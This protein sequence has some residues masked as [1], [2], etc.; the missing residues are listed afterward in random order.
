[1]AP[2]LVIA[3]RGSSD[4]FPE[5]T[6]AAYERA[7]SDGADGWECDVRL[8]RDGHLVC[9]HDRRVDRTSNGWG[10]VSR[11][12]LAELS[13]LDFTSWKGMPP[14]DR[15]AVARR[16]RNSAQPEGEG[17][18]TLE[19]LLELYVDCGQE[20]R[21]LIE[22]KHPTRFGGQVELALAHMLR[23]FNLADAG[24]RV[25]VMSM[26]PRALR[27]MRRLTPGVPSVQLLVAVP[28][29]YRRG[30][31]PFG[32][33]IAGPWIRVLRS[34]PSYVERAHAAGK[35]VFTWTVDDDDDVD[36]AVSLGVD[37]IITNRPAAVRARIARL[38]TQGR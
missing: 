1:M 34:F 2:P 31:L 22:T 29:M 15:R 7:I 4:S 10:P 32:S 16:R 23:R 18:L 25:S 20:L 30:A 33:D 9:V 24:D 27:R 26:W 6:L 12:Q 38:T 8:T 36:L 5:H 19:N 3:H 28:P 21:L 13:G 11:R 14:P 35:Q 17:V 37:A